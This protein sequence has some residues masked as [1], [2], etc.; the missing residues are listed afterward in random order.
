VTALC[1]VTNNFALLCEVFRPTEYPI[2]S[3]DR[4]YIGSW[5]GQHLWMS[6]IQTVL[7][8]YAVDHRSWAWDL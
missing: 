3:E 8:I 4:A 2:F 1:I 6:W 7:F 5:L